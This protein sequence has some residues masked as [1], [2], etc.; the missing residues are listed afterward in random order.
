MAINWRHVKFNLIEWILVPIFKP[1]VRLLLRTYRLDV[2]SRGNLESMLKIKSLMIATLHGTSPALVACVRD[3][4]SMGREI[5]VM[6]SPSRD[7]RLM[8]QL[9]G[10]IGLRSVKGSSGSRSAAGAFAM[11]EAM[12]EGCV[13]L[14]AVDGPR[15][16]LAVPKKGIIRIPVAV[17]ADL[18]TVGVSAS[19]AIRLHSWDRLFIPLPFATIRFRWR[20]FDLPGEITPE[21]EAEVLLRLQRQLIEDGRAVNCPVVDG[22]ELPPAPE[23]RQ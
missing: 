3:A 22:L 21:N 11:A 7:G 13:A 8:D 20:S 6:T 4:R 9:V 5:T 19:S 12:R 18:V 23:G 15:G 1:F 10:M 16:P 14:L 17:G 2:E